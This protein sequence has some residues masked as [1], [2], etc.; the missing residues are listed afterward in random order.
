MRDY[1]KYFCVLA[2]VLCVGAARAASDADWSDCKREDGDRARII[3]ACARIAGDKRSPP[4]ERAIALNNRGNAYQTNKDFARAIADY[5]AAL[6]LDPS[7]A[8]TYLNRALALKEEGE[9]ARAL[10]DVTKALELQPDDPVSL[11]GRGD[12]YMARGK[13]SEGDLDAAIA[14]YTEAIRLDPR[15]AIAY[16]HRGLAFEAKGDGEHASADYNMVI[17]LRTK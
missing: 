6:R 3:A 5:D 1:L 16:R 2:A 4:R 9:Y 12:V 14:D 11:R 13:K 8:H 17:Q 15:D 10:A 7:L